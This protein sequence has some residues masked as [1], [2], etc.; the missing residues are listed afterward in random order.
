LVEGKLKDLVKLKL[1]V[2]ERP[3]EFLVKLGLDPEVKKSFPQFDLL[4]FLL[5]LA[6]KR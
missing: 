3:V 6:S 2:D 4:E 5:Q 1:L